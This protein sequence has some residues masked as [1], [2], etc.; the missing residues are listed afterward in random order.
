MKFRLKTY[1][2]LEK[3]VE[4][5]GTGRIRTRA[6]VERVIMRCFTKA[7]LNHKGRPGRYAA[8]FKNGRGCA[9]QVI[10]NIY[11]RHDLR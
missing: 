10:R 2:D 11:T 6:E 1:T 5:I 3:A 7:M 8:Q 9:I 4:K